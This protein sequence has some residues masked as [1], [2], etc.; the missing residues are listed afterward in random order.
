M[1]EARGS[2]MRIF[3]T[4]LAFLRGAFAAFGVLAFFAAGAPVAA[5]VFVLRGA[6][7]AAFDLT[8]ATTAAFVLCGAVTAA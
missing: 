4:D 2:L 7:T 6:A 8:G 3:F 1:R 5:V